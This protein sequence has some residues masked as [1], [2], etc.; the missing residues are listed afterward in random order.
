MPQA[1]CNRQGFRIDG[2]G[3]AGGGGFLRSKPG[4]SIHP[5]RD[6]IVRCLGFCLI[7]GGHI[8]G[9]FVHTFGQVAE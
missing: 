4:F 9:Y 7:D 6:L 8:A 1:G 2:I 5:L 3:K